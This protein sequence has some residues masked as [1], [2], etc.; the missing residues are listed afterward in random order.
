MLS[1]YKGHHCQHR[2]DDFPDLA[3]IIAPHRPQ[4]VIELGTDEGGFSGWLADL[5]SPW[6]GF[7]HTFDIKPKFKPRLLDDFDNLDFHEANVLSDTNKLVA[8]LIQ[9][10]DER[11]LL[12]CDNGDKQREV[13]LYAPLLKVGDLLATHDYNT[14]IMASWV[15]P[16]VSY[17]GFEKE[18][19]ERMEALRN[20]WY[21]E[22]MTRFWIRRRG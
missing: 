3:A 13:E 2:S 21:P 1:I 19:H 16:F 11:V 18:G 6:D 8:K 22:P 15:E 20:E 7:V 17:L 14:E 10:G 9:E 5:V 12:Y 4:R